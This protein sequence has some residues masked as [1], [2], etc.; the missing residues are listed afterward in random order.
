MEGKSYHQSVGDT[1]NDSFY[2]LVECA[3]GSLSESL[4]RA[5]PSHAAAAAA[6]FLGILLL[7]LLRHTISE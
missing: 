7:L 6:Q 5:A 4:F 2:R 3:K 1:V